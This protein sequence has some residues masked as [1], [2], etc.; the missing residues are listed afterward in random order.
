MSSSASRFDPEQLRLA[1]ADA[2]PSETDEKPA[3]RH[4]YVPPRHARALSPDNSLVVGIRGV[5]SVT[6]V[7]RPLMKWPYVG[8]MATSVRSGAGA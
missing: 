6:R 5:D 7:K 2:L 1:L 8:S 3:P 4:L